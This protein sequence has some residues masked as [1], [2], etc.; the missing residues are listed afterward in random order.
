MGDSSNNYRTNNYRINNESLLLVN[1]LNTMY[2]DNLRQINNLTETLNNLNNSNT[3]IRNLLVQL[4][5][6]NQ[7]NNHNTRRNQSRRFDNFDY[8]Y[9]TTNINGRNI[10]YLIGEYTFPINRN[11]QTNNRNRPPI[12]DDYARSVFENFFQPIE[13]YPTQSQIESATRNVRYCDIARPV[14]TCCPISMDDFN[15]NDM[16]TIIRH[17]GHIFH[18][19]NIMNWFRSNC[20]CPVCRYDIRDYN[21]N[22]SS[23]FFNNTQDISNN[24]LERSNNQNIFTN[25]TINS[26]ASN[27][28]E[29]L[30]NTGVLDPSGNYTNSPTNIITSFLLDSLNRNMN[31]R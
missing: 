20:R 21:S 9:L 6:T 1:I 22:V 16:V 23:Q 3:E 17:C 19:E 14:N 10:G 2:N 27:S 11:R 7:G 13:I 30:F 8:N 12:I 5:N 15:D 28:L 18:T 25:E 4:I 29:Q 31:T 26:I 24:N